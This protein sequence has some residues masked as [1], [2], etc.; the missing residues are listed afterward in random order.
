MGIL[1]RFRE[2]REDKNGVLTGPDID[3][4]S[5]NT[6]DVLNTDIGDGQ[7]Y[8]D[9]RWLAQFDGVTRQTAFESIDG[10]VQDTNNGGGISLS[11]IGG[12]RLNSGTNSGDSDA[13]VRDAY[14][15]GEFPTYVNWGADRTL[16]FSAD[17]EDAQGPIYVTSGFVGPSDKTFEHFGVA[18]IAGD[19]VITT[20][21][22]AS[23][24]TSTTVIS[25]APT[26]T[27]DILVEL[28]SGNSVTATVIED[29]NQNTHT[30]TQ[31][32]TIPTGSTSAQNLWVALVQ[33]GDTTERALDLNEI[34]V[35][36]TP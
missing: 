23:E 33:S 26:G 10:Y 36:Q 16:R 15:S 7:D 20:G 34:R 31:S 1:R 17:I 12:V 2:W 8:A 35:V 25:S 22:G 19:L 5:I 6:G 3:A 18:M 21:D 9:P 27:Y 4:D 11:G 13:T 29:P 30:A 32:T 24:D 14:F 28:D